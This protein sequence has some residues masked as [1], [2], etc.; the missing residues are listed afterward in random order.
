MFCYYWCYYY[1]AV[2]SCGYT[3]HDAKNI[4]QLSACH[5]SKILKQSHFA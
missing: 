2:I 5:R 1:I 3:A 4:L